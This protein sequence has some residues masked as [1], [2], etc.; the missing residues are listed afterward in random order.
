METKQKVKITTKDAVSILPES[1][2]IT[3]LKKAFFGGEYSLKDDLLKIVTE[4]K[5]Q[6][7]YKII[8]MF[9]E[10]GNIQQAKNELKT[11]INTYMREES[12]SFG[13][14][15]LVDYLVAIGDDH[16][17]DHFF[18]VLSPTSLDNF[19]FFFGEERATDDSKKKIRQKAKE[20]NL[21]REKWA[22]QKTG[23]NYWKVMV[24]YFDVAQYQEGIRFVID[25]ADEA[26]RFSHAWQYAKEH[27]IMQK[28]LAEKI[29][30]Q[31]FTFA[32]KGVSFVVEKQYSLGSLRAYHEACDYLGL[33]KKTN[34]GLGK[35]VDRFP[36]EL[37]KF[38]CDVNLDNVN[39]E[40]L[41]DYYDLLTNKSKKRIGKCI[42]K[43]AASVSDLSLCGKHYALAGEED[44]AKL[45]FNKALD[46]P[47]SG[48]D[49]LMK[50]IE[51]CGEVFD[52]HKVK[53][54]L[55]ESDYDEALLAA[56]KC[57]HKDL[58]KIQ[59]IAEIMRAE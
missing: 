36:H 52:H 27:K 49:T 48:K 21:K 28:E 26:C 22:F 32:A 38:V 9:L 4:N 23:K 10:N 31:G 33:K 5:Q 34:F 58:D 39:V 53:I 45:F 17:I 7:E 57:E 44:N 35:E 37:N 54:F 55:Q 16:L 56:Q 15:H 42:T 6:Y 47:S 13:G 3:V 50:A 25:H 51:H 1:Q 19:L 59:V 8:G 29:A 12:V 20:E 30:S 46:Q 2:K 43:K 41:F 24:A 18:K 40:A 11:H 14:T